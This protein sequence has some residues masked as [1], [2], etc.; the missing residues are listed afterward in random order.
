MAAVISLGTTM[1]AEVKITKVDKA[2]PTDEIFMDMALSAAKKSVAANGQP[3]GAVIILNG[4]WKA[5]G[6][7][8]AKTTPEED[9]FSKARRSNLNNASVY[10]INEPTTETVNFLNSLGVESI[11][12]VNGRDAV[13]AA[14]IYPASAYND[15]EINPAYPAAPMICIPYADAAAL[16]KK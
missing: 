12:F 6:M 5:S 4:A 16:I 9:A 1:F 13:V 11:Y 15:D 14:G 10:T 2:K 7:P 8:T 3:S